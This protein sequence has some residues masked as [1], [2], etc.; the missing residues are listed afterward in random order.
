MPKKAITPAPGATHRRAVAHRR[1]RRPRGGRGP[2]CCGRSRRVGRARPAFTTRD[3]MV[4]LPPSTWARISRLASSPSSAAPTRRP[5][6]SGRSSG[7]GP[8]RQ[9]P[10]QRSAPRCSAPLTPLG[11]RSERRRRA[12]QPRA[13][14]PDACVART[15]ARSRARG[16]WSESRATGP[17]SWLTDDDAARRPATHSIS[18]LQGGPTACG[19]ARTGDPSGP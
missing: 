9:G 19:P 10:H 4:H 13:S 6:P 3:E 8:G 17:P 1:A 16:W 2:Q 11:R 14:D 12:A 5:A 18:C 7:F 15:P